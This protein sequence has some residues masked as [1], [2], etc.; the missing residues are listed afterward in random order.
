MPA[1]PAVTV[2]ESS[3]WYAHAVLWTTGAACLSVCHLLCWSHPDPVPPFSSNTVVESGDVIW[4]S[5]PREHCLCD[6]RQSPTKRLDSIALWW[7][8][9]IQQG[10]PTFFFFL[11]KI[12]WV[13][14]RLQMATKLR[15]GKLPV[16]LVAYNINWVYG[17]GGSIWYS[18][19]PDIISSSWA[20]SAYSFS[21]VYLW[22]LI[23]DTKRKNV[24]CDTED[25]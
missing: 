18:S 16:Y 14:P 5:A 8:E 21:L 15:K 23:S 3:H 2:A 1:L 19:A 12:N 17:A 24:H 20:F 10:L 4:V 7:E 13:L 22:F 11:R 25:V 6:T 9:Y